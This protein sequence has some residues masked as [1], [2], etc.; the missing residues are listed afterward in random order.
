[1]QMFSVV[2][3]QCKTYSINITKK[4]KQYKVKMN[5]TAENIEAA[6]LQDAKCILGACLPTIDIVLALKVVVLLLFLFF[7]V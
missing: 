2:S 7:P 1:M 5:E 3:G 4:G 6:Y